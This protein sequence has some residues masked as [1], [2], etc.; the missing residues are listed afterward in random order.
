MPQTAEKI[1]KKI[2]QKV[3]NTIKIYVLQHYI[4]EILDYFL[5]KIDIVVKGYSKHLPPYVAQSERDDL[6]TLAQL[7]FIE[8]LKVWDPDKSQDLWPLAHAR[9]IGAMRDHIRYITKSDPS[10]F[11]EWITDAAYLYMT[12]NNRADVETHI[13]TGMQLNQAMNTLTSRER[14]IVIAHTKED[15]TFKRIGDQMGI[16]ESQISRIYKKAIQ[17]IKKT[18]NPK[19]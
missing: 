15:Q 7:E 11:Y 14:K 17:K 6:R 4:S 2:S 8:T 5:P 16:S 13:E 3:L 9:I 1:W 10:R 18:L 19:F 12:I